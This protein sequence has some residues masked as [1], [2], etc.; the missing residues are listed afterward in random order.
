MISSLRRHVPG[1]QLGRYLVV[2]IWNTAFGYATFALFNLL[3]EGRVPASYM[4]ASLLASVINITVAFL[5]YKWFVFK[6]RG[7][8]LQGVGALPDGLQRQHRAW[9]RRCCRPRCS[10][11]STSPATPAPRRTSPAPW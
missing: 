6:T 1:G 8:Y 11:W 7:N 5:G 10:S 2:G 4:V 9:P 3:L